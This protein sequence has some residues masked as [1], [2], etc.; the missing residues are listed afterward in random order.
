MIGAIVVNAFLQPAQSVNQAERLK[1]EF[2]KLNVEIEIISNGEELTSVSNGKL[3]SRLEKY[4]FIIFLDKDKYLSEILSQ[5]S[6][7]MF[8]SHNS[9]RLCDDKA[10]TIIFLAQK[11]I[12]VPD[13]MFGLLSY[14]K[15]NVIP[16]D[17]LNAII[18][19]LSLPV[20]VK[21]SYGSMG[22]GV[23]LAKSKEE[24]A[25]ILQEIK[26]KPYILQKYLDTALGVDVRIIVIGGK[27]VSCIKRI[28]KKDFRSNVGVGGSG[29]NFTPPESFIK[30]A[31]ESAK[32]LE[33]DFCGVDLLFDENLNPVVCEVNSNAFFE[34]TEKV[35]G[36]NVAELYA[37]HVLK[38]LK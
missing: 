10:R 38:R 36:I 26:L 25:L 17:Y 20:V 4:D 27:A 3:C 1:K 33:L 30:V 29:E 31:E 9:I 28:N 13:T 2:L 5:L 19:R 14:K 12:P 35:T 11:G 6:I 34:E 7:P 24:L 18:N 21:E 15:E 37:K 32:A 8:N 23:Y 22:K 16:C